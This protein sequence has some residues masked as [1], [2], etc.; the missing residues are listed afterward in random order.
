[1]RREG[2]RHTL[3]RWVQASQSASL[4]IRIGRSFYRLA[5]R[6]S[7]HS[8]ASL[9]FRGSSWEPALLRSVLAWGIGI[10]SLLCAVTGRPVTPADWAIRA[11]LALAGIAL[12]QRRLSWP[13][14]TAGS[15]FLRLY[16][17]APKV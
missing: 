1:M 3:W 10:A 13:Q 5:R 8:Q 11:Y 6:F 9:L 12:S 14:I 17:A 2:W 7:R 16:G 4:S 15:V